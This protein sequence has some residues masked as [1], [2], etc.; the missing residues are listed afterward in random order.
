MRSQSAALSYK[1]CAVASLTTWEPLVL[2][3]LKACTGI[4]QAFNLLYT[5]RYTVAVKESQALPAAYLR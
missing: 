4:P 2:G 3:V 5:R 1:R